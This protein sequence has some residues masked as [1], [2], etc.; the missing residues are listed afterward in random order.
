M[1]KGQII[2]LIKLRLGSRSDSDLDALIA[3]ELDLFQHGLEHD[4]T[5]AEV[6]FLE[7]RITYRTLTANVATL[8]LPNGYLGEAEAGGIWILDGTVTTPLKRNRGDKLQDYFA[9]WT[10]GTPTAY[11]VGKQLTFFPTPSEALPLLEVFKG[12][13][14]P[15][16]VLGIADT[17][18]WMEEAPDLMIA[19]VG[20]VIAQY[21]KDA[22]AFAM[23]TQDAAIAR[24]RLK[25][26]IVARESE[27]R[28]WFM[29]ED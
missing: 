9:D 21:I 7:K 19:G 13:E 16:S 11:A 29:G 12:A 2:S 24:A 22:E 26:L 20:R 27:G 28:D 15:P 25:T 23:F 14:P 10:P 4:P 8:P 17:N 18:A 5:L 1:N 3:A 6:W